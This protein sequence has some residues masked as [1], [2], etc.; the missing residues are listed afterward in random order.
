MDRTFSSEI[1]AGQSKALI[2]EWDKAVARARSW[3][4]N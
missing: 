2:Q 4:N 3:E 1:S